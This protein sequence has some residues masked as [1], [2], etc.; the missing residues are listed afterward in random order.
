MMKTAFQQAV[1]A[2]PESLEGSLKTL[3][4]F[5]QRIAADRGSLP[6]FWCRSSYLAMVGTI[7][8][9]RRYEASMAN[10]T[11]SARGKNRYRATPDSRNIGANTMQMESVE[12]NAGVAICERYRGQSGRNPCPAR[13]ASC[14]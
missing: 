8:R 11:A 2:F 1:I 9:E 4:P 7:V 14:D 10:T 3:L 5:D 6:G 13:L 12:T